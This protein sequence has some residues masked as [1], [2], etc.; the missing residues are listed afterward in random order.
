MTITL[1]T[2]VLSPDLVTSSQ[3]GLAVPFISKVI[4]QRPVGKG[5]CA[6]IVVDDKSAATMRDMF[7][8]RMAVSMKIKITIL[9]IKIKKRKDGET[10][11]V[12][13]VET[14]ETEETEV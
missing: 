8:N 13:V 9:K 2:R 5:V 12:K 6:F 4:S 10:G 14:S 11:K 1:P 3:P 7:K